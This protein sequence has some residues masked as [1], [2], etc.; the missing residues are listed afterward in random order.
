[1][2]SK[3]SDIEQL[4][5]I[6]SILGTT[7]KYAEIIGEHKVKQ[8]LKSIIKDETED[9]IDLIEKLLEYDPTKRITIT[10]AL[11]HRYFEIL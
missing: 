6:C 9:E 7:P 2:T 5:V 11:K 3:F 10:E 1:M 8:D 4:K